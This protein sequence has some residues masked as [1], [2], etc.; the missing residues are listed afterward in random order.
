MAETAEPL[1]IDDK[2]TTW[3]TVVFMLDKNFQKLHEHRYRINDII[4]LLILLQ[5]I[6]HFDKVRHL[7]DID[8]LDHAV[9]FLFGVSLV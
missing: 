9:R 3:Q 6:I 7:Q 5:T 8:L 1:H 2:L 4:D